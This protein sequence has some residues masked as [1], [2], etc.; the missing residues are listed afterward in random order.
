MP[1]IT[2]VAAK[3]KA[4]AKVN[5]MVVFVPWVAPG[6][7]VDIQLT[8]KKNSYAEGHAIKI[9]IFINH[10]ARYSP[11]AVKISDSYISLLFPYKHVIK[12]YCTKLPQQKRLL[13]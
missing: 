3:G 4:L 8:R 2:D 13:R 6:D 1:E 5:D 10:K 7:V 11:S 12:V 9:E